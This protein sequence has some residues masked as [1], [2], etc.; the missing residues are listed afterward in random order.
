MSQVVLPTPYI[1]TPIRVFIPTFPI[2]LIVPKLPLI[3]LLALIHNHPVPLHEPLFKISLVKKL[4][5]F[6]LPSAIKDTIR[7]IP[8]VITPILV[9]DLP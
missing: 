9:D 4:R 1:H 2:P 8:S 3:L 5:Q 7:E 6:E